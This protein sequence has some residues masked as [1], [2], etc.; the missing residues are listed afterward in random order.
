MQ[1]L[2]MAPAT[3]MLLVK[4]YQQPMS[5]SPGLKQCDSRD[6]QHHDVLSWFTKY[7]VMDVLQVNLQGYC[8]PAVLPPADE[9]H[10]WLVL[11]SAIFCVD[12][13]G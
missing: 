8:L 12:M 6:E 5:T 9:F 4:D 11:V 10:F 3:S 1:L 7:K 13:P 2:P